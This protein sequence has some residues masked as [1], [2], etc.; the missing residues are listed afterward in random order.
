MW[1]YKITLSFELDNS[2]NLTLEKNTKNPTLDDFKSF[3]VFLYQ[4]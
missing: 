4:I 1:A 2:F 3:I